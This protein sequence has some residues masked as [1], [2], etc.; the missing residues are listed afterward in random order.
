MRETISACIITYNEEKNIRRCLE[1]VQ[2]ADEIIVVDSLSTDR[3]VEICREFTDKIVQK[4]WPGYIGQKNFAIDCASNEWVLCIDADE[5]V[6]SELRQEILGEFQKADETVDGYFCP[7][8]TFYLGKWI[9]HGGWY[10]DYKLRLFKRSKGRWGGADPH[11]KVVLSGKAKYLKS[12]LY[13][14][15][16]RNLSHQLKTIDNFSTISAEI[17][18]RQGKR[19]NLINL[20]IRPPIKFITTYIFKKGF[21]DGLPGLIISVSSSFYVFLKYAKLWEKER[22]K[23]IG[24]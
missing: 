22:A 23:G 5:M 3:T 2:W 20:L 6:S 1:S 16:Y 15:T 17:F 14:F 13:H 24:G 11:D 10:P 18:S 21:L 8:R 12:D 9:K 4:T 19:F 7:R